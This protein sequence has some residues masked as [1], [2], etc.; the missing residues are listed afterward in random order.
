MVDPRNSSRDRSAPITT[1]PNSEID[2]ESV[3]EAG[4]YRRRKAV[5]V[6][7]QWLVTRRPLSVVGLNATAVTAVEALE[8]DTFT[9][10][11]AVAEATG[12]DPGAVR[13]LFDSL[14]DRGVLA[15]EP[16]STPTHRPPVSVVVTV[17]NQRE[18][19]RACLDALSTLS[20][21][22]YEVV[23]VDDGS[24]DGTP[25]MAREHDLAAA[26]QLRVFEVDTPEQPLGIGPSRNRGVEAASH[27]VIAFTDADCRPSTGWLTELLGYLAHADIVGGRIRPHGSAGVDVYEGLHSSLDMG[28]RPARV[29]PDSDTPYLATANLVGRREVFERVSFPDRSV[30]EDVDV[31]FRAIA[32]GY[33]AVYVPAGLVEHA[34]APDARTLVRRRRS[35]GGSEALLAREYGHGK[36]VSVTAGG[37]IVAAVLVA[38]GLAWLLPAS[39]PIPGSST[40]PASASQATALGTA[41]AI[42]VGFLAARLTARAYRLRDLVPLSSVAG[43]VVRE[44]LS[45]VYAVTRE[46]TRYYSLPLAGTALLLV[47]AGVLGGAPTVVRAGLGIGLVTGGAL[48]LPATVEY[49]IHRP[50]LDPVRYAGW[51]LADHLGYQWGVYRGAIAHGTAAHLVPWRRFSIVWPFINRASGTT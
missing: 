29:D 3:D 23:V 39:L 46:F 7:D 8:T 44:H 26:G 42:L 34:F 43:S 41:V 16:P 22:E 30:A 18:H 25:A 4:S 6:R 48:A 5:T 28:P 19:L 36:A 51:Y 2:R 31:C 1:E 27:D 24:T 11:A 12:L 32:Q 14:H 40:V 21:P 35:Y 38:V 37:V 13:G 9:T 49:T 15:W 33:E 17:R 45:T 10:P 20:Y 47:A 50:A